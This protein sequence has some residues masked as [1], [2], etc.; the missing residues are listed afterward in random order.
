[1]A[2][3]IFSGYFQIGNSTVN[4]KKQNTQQMGFVSAGFT[5]SCC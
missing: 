3:S 4:L 5:V 2:K 1:M